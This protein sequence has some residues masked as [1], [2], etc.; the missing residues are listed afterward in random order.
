[1]ILPKKEKK[2][3]II[4]GISGILFIILQFY[5]LE[6]L[7]QEKLIEYAEVFEKGYSVGFEN[8]VFTIFNNTEN[9]SVTKIW[10]GNLS[11][12][13]I[14]FNCSLKEQNVTLP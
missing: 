4:I 12:Y 3:I 7:E 11:K 10:V 1:L 9:C 14:D 6:F 13:I 2:I 5:L 8:S